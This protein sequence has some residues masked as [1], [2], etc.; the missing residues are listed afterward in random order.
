MAGKLPI[1][2][3]IEAR[4]RLITHAVQHQGADEPGSGSGRRRRR[5]PNRFVS[6]V[7]FFHLRSLLGH[8]FDP[9]RVGDTIA[10]VRAGQNKLRHPSCWYVWHAVKLRHSAGPPGPR[11]RAF[12]FN[13]NNTTLSPVGL[14]I[15]DPRYQQK[16]FWGLAHY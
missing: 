3:I 11:S 16:F 5:I 10:D 2:G 13:N 7:E 1:S 9:I 8:V 6:L 4:T 15:L 12:L 14:G